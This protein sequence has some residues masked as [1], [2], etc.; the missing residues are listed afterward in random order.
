MKSF[1]DLEQSKVLEKILPLESADFAWNVFADGSARL[2]P[3]DDWDLQRGHGAK[4]VPCWSLAALLEIIN[5]NFYTDLHHDGCAWNI[6]VNHHDNAKQKFN[7]DGN[8]PVVAC[9]EMLL[10][11]HELKL[12]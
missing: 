5:K 12:L 7:R 3:A 8:T 2:L 10:T 9:Y 6:D 11:L 1:T 4:V